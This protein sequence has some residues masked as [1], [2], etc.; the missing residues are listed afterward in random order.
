VWVVVVLVVVLSV[1]FTR[2]SVVMKVVR[3]VVA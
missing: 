2:V 3:V 1:W